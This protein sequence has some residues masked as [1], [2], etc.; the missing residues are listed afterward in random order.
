MSKLCY[1]LFCDGVNFTPD[2]VFDTVIGIPLLFSFSPC[3]SLL[4]TMHDNNTSSGVLFL[5]EIS[6]FERIEFCS[7]LLLSLFSLSFNVST[8]V[9]DPSSLFWKIKLSRKNY[10]INAGVL[11][12]TTKNNYSTLY[13]TRIYLPNTKYYKSLWFEV[14]MLQT[15]F[16]SNI[17]FLHCHFVHRWMSF[18]YAIARNHGLNEMHFCHSGVILSYV[19][20]EIF[21][22]VSIGRGYFD[23]TIL[24]EIMQFMTN[25]KCWLLFDTFVNIV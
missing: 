20:T 5:F 3:K 19:K 1:L 23:L 8:E 12:D 15:L 14:I 10:V 22:K 9:R 16:P 24:K 18:N 17:L 11:L 6:H 7:Q 25:H 4:T 2:I 13:I 21:I